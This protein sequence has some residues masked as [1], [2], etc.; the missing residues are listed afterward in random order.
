MDHLGLDSAVFTCKQM[1]KIV[2][3]SG[4]TSSQNLLT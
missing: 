2:I 4:L 1:L 3:L